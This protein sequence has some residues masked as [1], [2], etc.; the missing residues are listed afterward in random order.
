MKRYLN[1]VSGTCRRVVIRSRRRYAT[2]PLL[3]LALV[4][5]PGCG[6][7]SDDHGQRARPVAQTQT[8]A[9]AIFTAR[10]STEGRGARVTRVAVAVGSADIT[11]GMV[12][13]MM[14]VR[15]HVGE[16]VPDAPTFASCAA[17]HEHSAHL[18]RAA[19]LEVCRARYASLRAAALEELIVDEWLLGEA[20]ALG[21]GPT[22]GEVSAQ[23]AQEQRTSFPT[24][25]QFAAFL[26]TSG[27]TLVDLRRDVAAQLAGEALRA[28]VAKQVPS[29]TPEL[30]REFYSRHRKMFYVPERRDIEAVRTWRRMW[31]LRAKHEIENGANFGA[32][33]ERISID[34]PSN[35][36]GGVTKGIIPGQEEKGFNEAIFAS[37]PHVLE[38]PLRLRE[39]YYIFEVTRIVPG[40][41]EPLT[42]VRGKIEALLPRAN[43]S[44]ALET[45]IANWRSSWRAKTRCRP[46][47][48]I[49]KCAE[50][51][52]ARRK[53]EDP[54]TLN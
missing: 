43:Q 10:P 45:F 20:A 30:I 7:G 16:G 39:R 14:K 53:A 35:R 52:A 47:F 26:K 19:A 32:V 44:T 8:T 54:A 12:A 34:R 25:R 9:S 50:F 5:L 3:L 41:Q 15:G 22:V 49:Q 36:H 51:P 28:Y 21:V 31:I 13:H 18:A 48:V 37:P 27:Q 11:E 38:G 2:S 6:G 24:Q 17:R 29:V 23:F 46:G 4:A 33:A 40:H 1:A 42:K